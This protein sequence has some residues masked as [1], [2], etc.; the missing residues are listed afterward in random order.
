M[1]EIR[2]FFMSMK[3]AEEVAQFLM[4]L[5]REQNLSVTLTI[6]HG[7]TEVQVQPWENV[8]VYCPYHETLTKKINE[9]NDLMKW[10]SIKEG[11]P[12]EDGEYLVSG[13]KNVWIANFMK[14]ANIHGF[15]NDCHNPPIEAWMPLPKTYVK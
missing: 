11:Y 3:D 12:D 9:E 2:D 7:R 10:T 5:A 14:L 15:C 1:S 13:G 8:T 6:E 4:K